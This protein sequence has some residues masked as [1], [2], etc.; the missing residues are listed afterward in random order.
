MYDFTFPVIWAA[1]EKLQPFT[2]DA[3]KSPCRHT[4]INWKQKSM[5]K[6]HP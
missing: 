2:A 4:L 1:F 6:S 3:Q 5:L